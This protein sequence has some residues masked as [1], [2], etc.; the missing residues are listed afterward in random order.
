MLREAQANRRV[1]C[2]G[3]FVPADVTA[4]IILGGIGAV[5]QALSP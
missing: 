4:W 5:L 3:I 2:I 1:L